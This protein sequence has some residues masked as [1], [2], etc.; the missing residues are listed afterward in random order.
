MDSRDAKMPTD[1]HARHAASEVPLAA[2]G[3]VA[4]QATDICRPENLA[5]A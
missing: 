2:S 1:H 5:E 4:A 3:T